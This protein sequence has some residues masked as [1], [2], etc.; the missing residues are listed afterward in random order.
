[1]MRYIFLLGIA[2]PFL[3]AIFGCDTADPLPEEPESIIAHWQ[4]RP[5]F[6]RDGKKIVFE[7]NYDSV[8]AIHFVDIKGNYIGNLFK[9][10]PDTAYYADFPTWLPDNETIVLSLNDVLHTIK[11]T[12]ENFTKLTD[13]HPGVFMHSSP[14]GKYIVGILSVCNPQCGLALYDFS[15]DQSKL[16]RQYGGTAS[17]SGDSKNI[18]FRTNEHKKIAGTDK[19]EYLGFVLRRI[20]VY[21]SQEDS[22]YFHQNN[23]SFINSLAVSPDEKE[24]VCS[25]VAGSPPQYNLWKFIIETRQLIQLTFEGGDEPF[26]SPDGNLIVYINTKISEG[27]VWIMNRDGSNQHRLTKKNK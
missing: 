20:N 8:S 3:L 6:S 9:Q 24:I 15:K 18:Y 25:V 12:G 4:S 26:Y 27:G 23:T 2:L 13:S 1:M 16:I 10:N 17:W 7:G 5:E 19:S 11:Y 21:S 14:D 22:L